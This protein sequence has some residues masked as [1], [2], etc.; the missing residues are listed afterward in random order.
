MAPNTPHCVVCEC[1]DEGVPLIGLRFQGKA[2]WICPTHMPV[3]IHNPAQL[4][5]KLPGAENLKS[6]A[7]HGHH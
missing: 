4:A 7:C 5:D 1:T 2:A 6:G 3:L